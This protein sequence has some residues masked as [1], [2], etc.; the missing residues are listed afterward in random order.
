MLAKMGLG[1]PKEVLAGPQLFTVRTID[2]DNRIERYYQQ[3]YINIDRER[4][5]RW[6]VSLI[7]SAVEVRCGAAFQSFK[8]ADQGLVTIRYRQKGKEYSESAGCLIGADGAASPVRR[9]LAPG[10]QQKSYACIQEWFQVRESQPYFSSV[11]D[12]KITDFYS[13]VIP[14]DDCLLVG[15]A[16]DPQDNVRQRFALLK[17]RL[18]KSGFELQTSVRRNGAWLLRPRN[19]RQIC[20]G[21]GRIALT[22]EAAGWISPT[23]AEGLSYAFRSA[24]ALAQSIR[25]GREDLI[26]HYYRQTRDLRLNITK[27]TLKAPFM[28]QP[29]LRKLVMKSGLLSMEIDR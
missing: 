6:L 9:Q 4:F 7:P 12:R 25:Q 10:F 20:L 5:D 18:R 8:G 29:L 3:H 15:A 14:E 1:V 27:K 28:Y 2:L 17:E 19:S 26:R 24:T 22:G 13:W 16:I 11:F 23:S 21:A